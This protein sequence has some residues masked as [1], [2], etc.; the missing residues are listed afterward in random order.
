M[1]RVGR[2]RTQLLDNL[3]I[4]RRYWE[5]KSEVEV[6]KGENEGLSREHQ[7]ENKLSSRRSKDLVTSSILHNKSNTFN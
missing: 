7:K 4:R 1:K 6:G 5:L 3:R 2:R